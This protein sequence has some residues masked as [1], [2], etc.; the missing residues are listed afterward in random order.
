MCLLFLQL[1]QNTWR[2]I[3]KIPRHRLPSETYRASGHSSKE[4]LSR[5]CVARKAASPSRDWSGGMALQLFKVVISPKTSHESCGLCCDFVLPG[6]SLTVRERETGV[7]RLQ[8]KLSRYDSFSEWRCV[9]NSPAVA[10]P[11]TANVKV[12]VYGKQLCSF[13]YFVQHPSV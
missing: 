11:L 12:D 10:T 8:V 4:T 9:A 5:C 7:K 13:K 6:E 1:L 2:S 3:W